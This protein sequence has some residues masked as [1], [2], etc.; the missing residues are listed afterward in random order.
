MDKSAL[1]T[2]LKTIFYTMWDGSKTNAWMAEQ[3]SAAIRD[4][5]LTGEAETTDVGTAPAGAYAGTG[6]GTMT[7]N[8]DNL[9][10]DLT[11]TFENTEEN[12]FLAAHMAEDID[13]ACSAEDTV[14]TDTA[15]T[16]TTPI[17]VSSPFAGKGKGDF[18]GT[19]A[20][21]ETLLNLCFETMNAMT[22]GGDDYLAEQIAVA[23]DSYLKAGKISVTLQPPLA[24]AGQGGIS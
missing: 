5:I 7:I 6:K 11:P 10:G 24:G 23:V 4:Y 19:K 8:A 3:I 15:G 22:S 16:V 17:G 21:I 1:E 20:D 18:A 13:A 12:S 9:R 2:K 14:E